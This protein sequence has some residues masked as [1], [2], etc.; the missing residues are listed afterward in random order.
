M[1]CENCRTKIDNDLIFCTNC[2]ARLSE[3]LSNFHASEK[4]A[5][6]LSTAQT[7]PDSSTNLKWVALI[8]ALI[9]LPVSLFIGY[10]FWLNKTP[11]EIKNSNKSETTK[12]SP[13]K[14]PVN[15]SDNAANSANI[16]SNS[17]NSE[18]NLANTNITSPDSPQTN[19]ITI[20]RLEI[21][22]NSHTAY[23]FEVENNTAV[24]TG[25]LKVLQ[26]GQIL[27]YVYTQEAYDEHF[28]DP[29]HKMFSFEGAKTI[30]IEQTLI[31]GKYVL[32]FIN[33][34]ENSVVIEGKFQVK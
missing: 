33:E 25:E 18:T 5:P 22:P 16:T 30:N 27:G 10:L 21:A 7:P 6:K 9:T 4:T 13:T 34:N 19:T 15:R 29:I 17:V 1:I 23:P 32:V 11:L 20:E 26:G 31:D 12:V 24:I 28:P 14:K 3:T 2:G 8:I